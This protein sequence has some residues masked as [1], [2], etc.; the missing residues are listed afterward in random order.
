MPRTRVDWIEPRLLPSLIPYGT[1]VALARLRKH[2]ATGCTRLLAR[3]WGISLGPQSA[4]YGTPIFRR[5]PTAQV[6]IGESAIFRSADWSNSVGINRRC[7]VS[8]GRDARI[9]VGRH[10]G[11][12]AT[13]IAASTSITI[14]DRVLCGAN[15]TIVDTDRHPLD[16]AARAQGLP[17]EKAP[18]VIEDDVWLGMNVV[19][20]K[21]CHIG[22]G[23]VIAA[24][25]VVTQSLPSGVIAGGM[26]ARVLRE[27][28]RVN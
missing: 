19:V 15:C 27:I 25:S 14:G 2:V 28:E 20:L 5:H 4:F 23:T 11:F 10:C 13:V 8:A 3:W 16:P 26:P 6:T 9:Q 21:G 12:S 18:I 24:N 17:G 22:Q 1:A 7:F